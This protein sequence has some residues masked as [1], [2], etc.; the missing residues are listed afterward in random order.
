M[1]KSFYISLLYDYVEKGG[2]DFKLTQ[3]GNES[4]FV[5]LP[6]SKDAYLLD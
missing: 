5:P 1:G 6:M 3:L 4:D 2:Q